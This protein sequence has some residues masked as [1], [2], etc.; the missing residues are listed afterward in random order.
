MVREHSNI[1]FFSNSCALYLNDL[2]LSLDVLDHQLH[3]Y[4]PV[5]GHPITILSNHSDSLN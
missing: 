3:Q 4:H 2:S 5:S 1:T